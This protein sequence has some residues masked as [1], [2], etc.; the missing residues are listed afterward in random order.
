MSLCLPAEPDQRYAGGAEGTFGRGISYGGGTET[1]KKR[2]TEFLLLLGTVN[3][4]SDTDD[5]ALK[6]FNS[7]YYF[8]DRATGSHDIIHNQDAFTGIDGKTTSENPF[9]TFL[10]GEYALYAQLSGNFEGKDNAARGR[11]GNYLDIFFLE[12]LDN[13]SAE[14]F[15]VMWLLQNAELFPVYR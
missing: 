15:G 7:F 4:H 3:E 1:A 10:L 9:L 14:L 5:S 11:A 12:V 2:H 13:K 6:L 8:N